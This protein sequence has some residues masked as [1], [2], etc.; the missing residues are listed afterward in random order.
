MARHP[1]R[2]TQ[3]SAPGGVAAVDRSLLLL[4]A[5][6]E[7]DASLS[8][9]EL[10]VRTGLV[11][12]TALRLLAS[13]THFGLLRRQEDGRYAV[14][15]EVARLSAIHE[16]AFPLEAMVTPVLRELVARTQ[17]T[18]AFH[19]QRGER[20]ICVARVN[21]PQKLRYHSQ[22]GDVFPMDRGSAARVL[23]AFAGAEGALYD[24]I[25]AEKIVVLDG[26][27]VSELTGVSAPAFGPDGEVVGAVTLIVPTA[28]R[29]D[30]QPPAVRAAAEELTR[31]LGG[32]KAAF[33]SPPPS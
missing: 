21:S 2:P 6:R 9:A 24:R 13:L 7:G 11:K 20:R 22:V 33:A 3:D 1:R 8:L 25:R 29:D 32:P 23:L 14:G 4:R 17:E 30:S 5:F 27:R 28:R 15:P 18:A 12:S 19:V 26:D 10:A 16:A 31:R